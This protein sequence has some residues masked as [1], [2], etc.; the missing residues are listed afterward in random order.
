MR[1]TLQHTIFSLTFLAAGLIFAAPSLGQTLASPGGAG[2]T[3]PKKLPQMQELEDA[4]S[5]FNK[6]DM[7]NCEKSLNEALEK[8]ADLPPVEVMIA[9]MW[10]Q[11]KQG[12]LM[13]GWLDKAAQKSPDDP[14][15]YLTLG[16]IELQQRRVTAA[17]LLFT[18]AAA[19]MKNFNKSAER[20][21]KLT[22]RVFNDLA[23][24]SESREDWPTAQQR[25]EEALKQ[26][27]RTCSSCSAS[28]G[29]CSSRRKPTTLC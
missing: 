24:I 28:R 12:Q 20:K 2:D 15:A 1:V 4:L 13:M 26:D 16:E 8:N 23:A 9:Q 18:K 27:P 14:E 3:T 10:A 7:D 22:P 11:A 17:D 25:L 19:L 29:L 6:G 5:F 21:A